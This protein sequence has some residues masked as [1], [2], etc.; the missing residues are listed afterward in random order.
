MVGNEIDC[1]FAY[2]GQAQSCFV[3]SSNVPTYVFP[4]H[5]TLTTSTP[6]E[7]KDNIYVNFNS[8]I[9]IFY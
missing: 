5:V 7:R 2:L 9:K 4:R 3:E 8:I 1:I 6:A